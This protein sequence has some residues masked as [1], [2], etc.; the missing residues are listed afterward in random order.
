MERG[1]ENEYQVSRTKFVLEGDVKN[2][3]D[4]VNMPN[5]NFQANRHFMTD[6]KNQNSMVTLKIYKTD[7]DSLSSLLLGEATL[8]FEPEKDTKTA[9]IFDEHNMIYF[10]LKRR[11]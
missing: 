4:D 5:I 8:N 7:S 3:V 10:K 9:I 2:H 6:E 11:I 1:G